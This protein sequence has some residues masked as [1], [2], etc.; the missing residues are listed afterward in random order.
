MKYLIVK[1]YE[2]GGKDIVKD[3]VAIVFADIEGMTHRDVASL[4]QA[5]KRA[6]ISAGFCEINHDNKT[7]EV[8]GEST[9]LEKHAAPED[10][11]IIEKLF[12]WKK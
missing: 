6:V 4:H 3:I 1:V 8:Y 10:A 11:A 5:G 12:G 2:F 7:V 9:T